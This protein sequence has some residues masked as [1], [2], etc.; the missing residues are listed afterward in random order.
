M[1]KKEKFVVDLAMGQFPF[2]CITLVGPI[3]M[4]DRARCLT[5]P[6]R[7]A[8][9]QGA[10][11]RSRPLRHR[12]GRYLSLTRSSGGGGS[13]GKGRGERKVLLPLRY[14]PGTKSALAQMAGKIK[15]TCHPGEK[16]TSQTCIEADVLLL[17]YGKD[18]SA[19]SSQAWRRGARSAWRRG[20]RWRARGTRERR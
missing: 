14:A 1:S 19:L 13:E 2:L 10:H 3:L 11:E 9:N 7:V 20:E 5:V 18:H 15:S 17:P 8:S 12:R 16:R 6:G 4:K